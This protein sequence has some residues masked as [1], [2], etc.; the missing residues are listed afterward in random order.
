MKLDS[1][2]QQNS[3]KHIH[4]DRKR[5]KKSW[6]ELMK[7]AVRIPGISKELSI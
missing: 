6:K 3:K 2:I 5:I 4:I 1:F 7:G